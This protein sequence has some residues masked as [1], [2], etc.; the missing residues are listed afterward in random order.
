MTELVILQSPELLLGFGA[1]LFFCLFD[2]I[3]RASGYLFPALSLVIFLVTA[4]YSLLLGASLNEL[5]LVTL[6]FLGLNLSVYG[7]R[8]S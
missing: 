1:A 4:G 5:C 3:Y 2:K 8:T 7:R 6:I